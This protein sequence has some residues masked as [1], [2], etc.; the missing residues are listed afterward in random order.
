[1]IRVD[2]PTISIE[3]YDRLVTLVIDKPSIQNYTILSREWYLFEIGI[4]R[5]WP[6]RPRW[7]KYQIFLRK[8]YENTQRNIEKYKYSKDFENEFEHIEL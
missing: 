4:S 6:D 7:E 2:I 3:E 5:K 8:E 1:L